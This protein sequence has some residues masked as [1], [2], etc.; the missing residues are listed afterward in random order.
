[1]RLT[2]LASGLLFLASY[3][4]AQ[5][6]EQFFDG[7]P[8][9]DPLPVTIHDYPE[10][11]W[12]V[13]PPQKP[14]FDAPFSIPNAIA[15]DTIQACA[16]ND[17]SVF[18]YAVSNEWGWMIAAIR[19]MQ[20]LDMMPE[21]AYGIVEFSVDGETWTNGFDSPFVYNFYGFNE[22]NR[23]LMPNGQ[24]AF[25]GTDTTWKEIWFCFDGSWLDSQD[26]L[27]MRHTFIADGTPLPPTE[28]GYDGWMIDN[29]TASPTWVHTVGEKPQ[30][31]Y[32]AVS[33]NPAND[34]LHVQLQKRNSFHIIERMDL[35][36]P[37]GQR[38]RHIES[39]PTRFF[40]D[41]S[42]L[43]PGTYT[44]VVQSNLRTETRQVVIQH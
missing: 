5:I 23:V 31:D 7:L 25:G 32:L 14:K 34:R 33:P 8:V 2:I 1:M 35:Y 40:F 17:S 37:A 6:Y 20:K 38:V 24:Y 41:T 39:C 4:Q 15:T 11:T 3:G 44:L 36:S 42:D 26:T 9:N 29:L 12:Q 28:V 16:P 43:P 21:H 30:E 27:L 10:N 13:G 18:S 22:S 19:W